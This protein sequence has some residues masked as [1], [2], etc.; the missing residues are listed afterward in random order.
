[1][2]EWV[3]MDA[4]EWAV[5]RSNSIGAKRRKVVVSEHEKVSDF[6]VLAEWSRRMIRNALADPCVG[7]SAIQ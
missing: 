3:M 5:C 2:A 6:K 4:A 1:M 7:I